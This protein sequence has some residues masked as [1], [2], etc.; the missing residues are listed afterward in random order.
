YAAG[1]GFDPGSGAISHRGEEPVGP[2]VDGQAGC[3]LRVYREHEMSAD[4]AILKR[5]WPRVKKS[6]GYLINQDADGGGLV[7]GAEHNTLDAQWYGRVPWLSSLYLAALA[8]GEAMAREMQDDAFSDQCR[9]LRDRGAASMV[10]QL[11]NP[12]FGYFVQQG[13]PSHSSAVG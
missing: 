9:R 6:V 8:A 2:A 1:I 13:D 12:D 7:E 10:E 11:W 4:Q 5:L 3:I